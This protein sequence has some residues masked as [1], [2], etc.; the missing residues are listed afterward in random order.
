M[1]AT[2]SPHAMQP[3]PRLTP[4]G[5]PLRSGLSRGRYL[6]FNRAQHVFMRVFD[7]LTG[8]SRRLET[9]PVSVAAPR[10]V[11]L[12]M[13]AHIGDLIYASAAIPVLRAT[14]PEAKID[15]LV[16]PA[17][18]HLLAGHPD[19]DQLHVL[20][21][22]KLDRSGQPLWRRMLNYLRQRRGLLHQLRSRDYDLAIDL[23]AYFPNSVP[24][25]RAARIPVRLGWASGGFGG[26][27]THARDWQ[28]PGLHVL[29]WHRR[30]LASIPACQAHLDA[31]APSFPLVPEAVARC[32]DQLAAAGVTA[33]YLCFHVGAGGAFKQWHESAW[34]A[35]ARDA[36]RHGLPIVLLG[37]G[38]EEEALA[39]R[40]A[41]AA[42]GAVNLAGRLAFAELAACIAGARLFV[43]L[44]SMAIHL[45]AAFG[46]P[47][48]GIQPGIMDGSWRPASSRARIVTT[49]MPCSPCF[50]PG[51]CSRMSCLR[52]T[53]ASAASLALD[54]LLRPGVSS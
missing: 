13:Q 39:G 1:N 46:V 26:L 30:L 4:D 5:R 22:W 53:P 16:H 47:L 33:S 50:L 6:F 48:V 32:R 28:L 10:R 42:P 21:H 29:E 41:A 49:P 35:L 14:W 9:G 43:G 37:F 54:D 11:L 3:P 20:T 15:F 12:C 19:L 7:A 44:D 8:L 18:A 27:L 34:I 31:L 2:P 36:E 52:D 38:R 40:I 51:G 23:Y 24:L 17:A 25:L 45:A